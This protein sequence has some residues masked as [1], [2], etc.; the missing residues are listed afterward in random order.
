MTPC[1]A[2]ARWRCMP[3]TSGAV[4]AGQLGEVLHRPGRGMLKLQR[5]RTGHARR[6]EDA[7]VAVAR[8]CGQRADN[9]AQSIITPGN[10][11]CAIGA[12]ASPAV[13]HFLQSI[14]NIE[15]LHAASCL[16]RRDPATIT[17]NIICSIMA[18]ARDGG[19]ER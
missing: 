3:K 12:L 11:K 10:F 14:L 4:D 5:R 1:A 17:G 8:S 7:V 19:M 6:A 18:A 9:N 13:Y 15:D 2:A 16:M